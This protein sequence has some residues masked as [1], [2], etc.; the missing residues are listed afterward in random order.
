MGSGSEI[1]V[2]LSFLFIGSGGSA[3]LSSFQYISVPDNIFMSLSEH[4][5]FWR[6]PIGI[7]PEENHEAS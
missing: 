3:L 7:V 5:D 6:S 4:P 1:G 2:F